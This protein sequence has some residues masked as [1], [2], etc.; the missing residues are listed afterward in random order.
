MISK[1]KLGLLCSLFLAL[2]N[3]LAISQESPCVD[4]CST[5]QWTQQT[6]VTYSID[7][8]C[9]I[10]INY[11]TR[12]CNSASELKLNSIDILGNCSN[13]PIDLIVAEALAKLFINNPMGFPPP[14]GSSTFSKWTIR[15]NGCWRIVNSMPVGI[16]TSILPCDASVCCVTELDVSAPQNCFGRNF[17]ISK[18]ISNAP[19][20][21]C[22]PN[23]TNNIENCCN[24]CKKDLFWEVI[25]KTKGE[26]R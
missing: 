19:C 9:S 10:T 1:F 12:I 8:S 11:S 14:L 6:P 5:I 15:R 23:P 24:A 7:S 16:S 26:N 2:W 17:T 20:P 25:G 22:S 21:K 4:P 18:H 3:V 13:V